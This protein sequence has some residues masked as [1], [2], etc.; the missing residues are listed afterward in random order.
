MAGSLVKFLLPLAAV[1]A[2]IS[3]IYQVFEE[4]YNKD[5]I[6]E[7]FDLR[8]V[9]FS[10]FKRVALALF[11]FLSIQYISILPPILYNAIATIDTQEV[12]KDSFKGEIEK[13]KEK[14][15][16]LNLQNAPDSV[17]KISED[18]YNKFLN[19]PVEAQ[20]SEIRNFKVNSQNHV[21]GEENSVFSFFKK[22]DIK[23]LLISFLVVIVDL[24]AQLIKLLVANI[25]N[26]LIYLD[27][28]IAPFVFAFAILPWFGR[29]RIAWLS[30]F[31]SLLLWGVAFMLV[32]LVLSYL[33]MKTIAQDTVSFSDVLTPLLSIIVYTM[34]A[35]FGAKVV[36]QEAGGG[37]LQT[38]QR[39]AMTAVAAG[40][41][42]LAGLSA[43]AQFSPAG[44]AA[45][46]AILSGL[47][48]T[49]A[50]QGLIKGAKA[51]KDAKNYFTPKPPTSA[52]EKTAKATMGMAKAM[53]VTD[54]EEEE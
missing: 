10:A 5:S 13:W 4:Y 34:L 20:L 31:I 54:L 6:E 40:T 7:D 22:L 42:A 52:M 11:L 41:G 26:F 37:A 45:G 44:K 28:L 16:P 19:L 1:F 50:G 32:E 12:V 35:Y 3:F 48:K 49:K 18:E 25:Y 21:K 24:L 23:K 29:Q 47:N 33:A 39:G 9:A 15:N 30:S 27:I 17:Y 38:V 43:F 46:K 2:I 36:G 51:L 8:G 14:M 53:G